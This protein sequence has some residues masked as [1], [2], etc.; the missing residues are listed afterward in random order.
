M[1]M[2]LA[3][4]SAGMK[5]MGGFAQSAEGDIQAEN[6]REQAQVAAD[7]AARAEVEAEGQAL[8]SKERTRK[9]KSEQLVGFLKS[10]VQISGTPLAVL[11]K[12]QRVGDQDAANIRRSGQAR[13]KEY[14]AQS[15]QYM[16]QARLA[17]TK[18]R[19]ALLGGLFE[20][21]TGFIGAGMGGANG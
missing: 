7:A 5:I 2:G 9:L 1:G 21:V 20:G 6:A 8:Y 14:M 11:D 15:K 3:I 17:D 13:S 16:N 19:N 18:G 12:T 4:A 10:G